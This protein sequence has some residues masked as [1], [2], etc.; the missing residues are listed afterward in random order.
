ME[1]L[2]TSMGSTEPAWM[3]ENIAEAL[4]RDDLKRLAAQHREAGLRAV[5]GEHY[6]GGHWLGSFAVYLVT[7]YGF[8]QRAK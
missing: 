4:G 3:L 7:R 6:A 2:R 8:V 1:N 5:T